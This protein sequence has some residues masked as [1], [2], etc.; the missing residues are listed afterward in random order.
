MLVCEW[1][2]VLCD[3]VSHMVY[4]SC[5][6]YVC[7]CVDVVR[8]CPVVCKHGCC[9][10]T[11]APRACLSWSVQVSGIYLTCTEENLLLTY[12][13]G[14]QLSAVK[15]RQPASNGPLGLVKLVSAK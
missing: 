11:H 15:P 10:R 13:P 3:G 2:G 1:G 8:V 12:C 5:V 4:G 7:R 9:S 14:Q 6:A